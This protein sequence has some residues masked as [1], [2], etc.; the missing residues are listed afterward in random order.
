VFVR[1]VERNS[2]EPVRTGVHLLSALKRLYP[3]DFQWRISGIDRLAGTKRL[4]ESVDAGIHPDDIVRQWESEVERF[5]ELRN[6]YLL[7]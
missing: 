6:K 5:S 7:Y 3:D 2:F 4:R 1:V